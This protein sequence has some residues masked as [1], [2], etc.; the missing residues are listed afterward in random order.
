MTKLFAEYFGDSLV[1][2]ELQ[3]IIWARI[4]HFFNSPYYVY[5]Y[6]TSFA[7]SSRL[8]EKVTNEKYGRTSKD[9]LGKNPSFL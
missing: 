9:Y 7:A 3:K 6:A 5:Q 2:D 4:P 1:M 8:Y